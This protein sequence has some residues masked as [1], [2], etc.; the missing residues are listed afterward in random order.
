MGIGVGFKRRGSGE[1]RSVT[2][3]NMMMMMMIIIIISP[4]HRYTYGVCKKEE[5]RGLLQTE[6]TYKAV[7]IRTAEYLNTKHKEDQIVNI[8]KITI[9]QTIKYDST[10]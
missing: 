5:L 4:K 3:D 2:G 8:V 9:N 6:A 10:N 1:R 7:I